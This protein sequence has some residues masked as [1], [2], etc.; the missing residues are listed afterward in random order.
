[1]PRRRIDRAPG[2]LPRQSPLF[3]YTEHE[4]LSIVGSMLVGFPEW[5][6]LVQEGGVALASERLFDR[7]SECIRAEKTLR[8]YREKARA[9]AFARRARLRA[10]AEEG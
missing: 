3:K 1:M 4:I 9:R 2:A 8:E 7:A 6:R 5:K 10:E